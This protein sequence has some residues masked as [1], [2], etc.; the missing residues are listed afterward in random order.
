MSPDGDAIVSAL[1]RLHDDLMIVRM[2]GD[3]LFR[4]LIVQIFLTGALLVRIRGRR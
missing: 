3:W 2:V 1:T 4:A